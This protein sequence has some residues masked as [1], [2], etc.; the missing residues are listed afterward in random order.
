MSNQR[1]IE[2]IKRLLERQLRA[3]SPKKAA[4]AQPPGEKKK[5]EK[6]KLSLVEILQDIPVTWWG[7]ILGGV[8]GFLI[9]LVLAQVLKVRPIPQI[10]AFWTEYLWYT[11]IFFGI[12]IGRMLGAAL[13]WQ[14]EDHARLVVRGPK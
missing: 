5:F 1:E 7:M 11:L 14:A 6:K 8:L 13:D 4:R 10:D 3:R 2:R 9:A 12:A